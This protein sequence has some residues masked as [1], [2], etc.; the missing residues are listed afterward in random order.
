MGKKNPVA[1]LDTLILLSYE[2]SSNSHSGF[3]YATLDYPDGSYH[4]VWWPDPTVGYF[5]GKHIVLWIVAVI[6][7]LAGLFY[8]IVLLL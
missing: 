8:T 7:S 1:T 6:I 3:S 4:I 5:S 2:T